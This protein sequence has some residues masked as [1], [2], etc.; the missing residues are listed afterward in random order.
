M[1]MIQSAGTAPVVQITLVQNGD[2]V[3][4]N[5]QLSFNPTDWTK[6]MLDTVGAHFN[7]NIMISRLS[8]KVF[9][10]T[11]IGEL[12]NVELL[13]SSYDPYGVGN[14]LDLSF[15]G[16]GKGSDFNSAIIN[17]FCDMIYRM[18][19]KGRDSS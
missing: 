5:R 2:K 7:S 4:L 15:S 6:E 10:V 16:R 9:G 17:A 8:F 1:V 19:S 12:I 18:E 3:V 11:R 14:V 13:Y